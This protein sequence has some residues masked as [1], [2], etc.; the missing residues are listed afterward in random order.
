MKLAKAFINVLKRNHEK[1]GQTKEPENNIIQKNANSETS[2]A[3]QKASQHEDSKQDILNK[4][5]NSEESVKQPNGNVSKPAL[6]KRQLFFG[7]K[8][9]SETRDYLK[10]ISGNQTK[11]AALPASNGSASAAGGPTNSHSSYASSPGLF[12]EKGAGV[13]SIYSLLT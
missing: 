11:A 2:V 12:S 5:L 10:Q 8:S 9:K 7:N 3:G 13:Q 1:G 6:S 4:Y